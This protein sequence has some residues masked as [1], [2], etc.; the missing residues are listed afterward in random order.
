MQDATVPTGTCA[1]LIKDKER[2]LCANLAA[3]NNYKKTH[4]ESAEVQAVVK[5][6]RVYYIS[7]FF[8]TVST[9]S[10]MSVA[11]HSFDNNKVVHGCER[12]A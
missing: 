1:V 10:I 11:K 3:A 9:E 6:A 2:S 8:M 5:A 4:L 12:S 7:G